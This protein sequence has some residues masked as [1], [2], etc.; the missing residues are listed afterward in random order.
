MQVTLPTVHSSLHV[1][2]HAP[3]EQV[4]PAGQAVEGSQSLHG[5]L[6]A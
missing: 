5:S 4:C 1:G 6:S 3:F 2:A